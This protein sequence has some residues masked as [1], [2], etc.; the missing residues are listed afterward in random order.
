[1]KPLMKSSENFSHS[2]GGVEG[3]SILNELVTL[4]EVSG[5]LCYV[6]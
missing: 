4:F 2:M 6:H 1:M 3:V 5:I